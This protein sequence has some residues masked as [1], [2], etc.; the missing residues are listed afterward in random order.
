M[1]NEWVSGDWE[2]LGKR[3]SSR[4][5]D[6]MSEFGSVGGVGG[7]KCVWKHLAPRVDTLVFFPFNRLRLSDQMIF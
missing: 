6:E 2:F 5:L 4:Y 1:D 7:T 3:V